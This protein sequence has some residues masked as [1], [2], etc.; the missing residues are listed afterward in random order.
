MID[1][2]GYKKLLLALV[3]MMA[4]VSLIPVN[5]QAKGMKLTVHAKAANTDEGEYKDDIIVSLV[6]V[7]DLP[8]GEY[9]VVIN[10]HVEGPE[11]IEADGKL[12]FVCNAKEH[13]N[14][15]IK[16]SITFQDFAKF[17][18]FYYIDATA[19]LNGYTASD[20]FKFDPPGG[21]M[22]PPRCR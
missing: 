14:T 16:K 20:S 19:T 3:T 11:G 21:S 12:E 5:A 4:V 18:G 2:G 22:G 9:D 7:A 10:V 1:R 15:L 8:E 17:K 13:G 6:I